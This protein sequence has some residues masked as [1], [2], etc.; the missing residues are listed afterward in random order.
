M[1]KPR[2]LKKGESPNWKVGRKPTG[3]KRNSR[4]SIRLSEEELEEVNE[5]FS[6]VSNKKTDAFLI[7]MRKY[8]EKLIKNKGEKT[9]KNIFENYNLYLNEGAEQF[10]IESLEE[11]ERHVKLELKDFAGKEDLN[12]KP[13]SVEE[14]EEVIKNINENNK[15]RV[16]FFLISKEDDAQSEM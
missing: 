13:A 12:L 1:A 10:K 16:S 11:F 9:M 4:L 8:S 2:S 14:F 3:L 15:N 7:I 5:I 6:K